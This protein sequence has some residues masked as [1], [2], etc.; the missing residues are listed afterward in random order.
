MTKQEKT[1]LNMAR[2]IR[3]QTLTLLEKLND[4]DA[5]EQ[6]DICESLHDHA[7]ELYRSCLARFGDDGESN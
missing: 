6:A 1:A 2:F 4:L 7:D 5:D 3:N